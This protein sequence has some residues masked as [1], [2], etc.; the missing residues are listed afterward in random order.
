MTTT[1]PE[2][3]QPKQ[4]A[5][6]DIGTAEDFLAAVDETIKYFNDGD[7]VEG[8][9]VKV[10]RDE[11]LVDIG[12]KTEGVILARELSIKH[13]VDPGEVVEVGDDIEALVL[14]KEDKEGR[15]MLSKKRAQYE[16]AWGDIEKI[17]EDDGVVTGTVIE[18]VKGGLIVDIGL[19]GFLPASLVEMRRV[20]DLAPYIG[21]QV[22]AKII[23]LDKNRNNVVL[24]RRAWLE[25]TQSAVRH[26]F[27]QTLQK[28]QV[29]PGVVSSIVNFGAFVDLGGVDGLVHVSELS[30]KHIDHPGEVVTVGD[31]VTVEVLDVDM[32]RERVSL[33]LKATQEDPWQH[34]ARTHVIGQIVPGKVTK[35]VP[36][37]AFVRV[38][39][40]IE[41]LVHISELAVRHVDLPEQV[42][43]V[44]E[45]IYVKVIDI[46]LERRRISLSLKQANEGVDPEAEEFLDPALYGMPQEYDEDGNYKYPEG[47]DPE[48]NEWVEG[49]EAQRETWEQQ[50]AAAQE[51]WEEHKKQVAKAIAADAEASAADA[52][53]SAEAA[54]ATGSFSSEEANDEGTLASDEAL[55]ALREKL[56]GS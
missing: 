50:Y 28:G 2:S 48:T 7:I 26:D 41:G 38:E 27:L 13:D 1:T 33:S 5:V 10:D 15:L 34:F 46:D 19:R 3:V 52:V 23:E 40:G 8:E 21:Q 44:D 37:G 11:V 6:N 51:R 16:R 17:K 22:E 14:Q 39:D 47:F 29:R 53:G 4:V 43:S 25:Q 35:L 31:E 45:T 18:V 54:P 12:Y 42:V 55:A 30:W 32:D 9:V 24:S 49:Y 36:F 20:R 56:A